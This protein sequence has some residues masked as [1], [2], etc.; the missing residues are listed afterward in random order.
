M[1]DI[2]G[3]TILILFERIM[4]ELYEGPKLKGGS[5]GSLLQNVEVYLNSV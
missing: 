1:N 5:R 2:I 3:K 4:R